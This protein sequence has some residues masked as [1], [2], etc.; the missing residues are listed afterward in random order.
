[1]QS[2]SM[3][4]Y[5][6]LKR[7]KWLLF[8]WLIPVARASR[9]TGNSRLA[10][11]RRVWEGWQTGAGGNLCSRSCTYQYWGH[12]GWQKVLQ[13]SLLL[14]PRTP[15]SLDMMKMNVFTHYPRAPAFENEL[16]I[17]ANVFEGLSRIGCRTKCVC[18]LHLVFTI[19]TLINLPE[20]DRHIILGNS[21]TCVYASSPDCSGVQGS[22]SSCSACGPGSELAGSHACSSQ[23]SY[24][25][26]N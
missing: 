3:P 9:K 5:I 11:W 8:K 2:D 13:D 21:A 7:K 4:Q 6:F 12:G 16:G 23:C 14:S 20:I 19:S 10:L 1:M 17:S 26:D 25:N 22:S 18:T 24:R 15:D